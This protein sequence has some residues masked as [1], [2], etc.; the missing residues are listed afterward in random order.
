MTHLSV[1]LTGQ[2]SNTFYLMHEVP[3]SGL[4]NPAVQLKCKWFVGIPVLNS[5]HVSYGNSAFTYQ[6]LAGSDRWNLEGVFDQMHRVDLYSAAL[7]LHPLS[8]G[9]RYRSFYFNF[10][11]SEKALLLQTIPRD[12]PEVMLYGNGPFVG[13]SA[14][15]DALRPAGSYIREYALSVSKVLNPAWTVGARVKLHFGKANIYSGRS[16]L[17]LATEENSFDLLLEGD[18]TLNGSLPVTLAQDADGDITDITLNEVNYMQF[19]LNRGNPGFALDVGVIYRYDVRTTLAVSLLDVGFMRWR[20]DVHNVNGSGSFAFNGVDPGTDVISFDFLTEMGDS[21]INAYDYTVTRQPYT[22]YNPPQLYLGGSYQVKENLRV[23]VVNRNVILRNKVSSSL[24]LLAQVDLLDRFL[25]T[26]SWSY[27]NN[28][29]LNLGAGI[30][31]YGKG[32][33]FHLVSDNLPGFFFPF[34]TRTI[35]LR[36]GFN[37][38]FGCPRNKQEEMAGESYGRMPRGGDCSWSGKSKNRDKQLRKA[39]RR[40]KL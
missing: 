24:T 31:Y 1:S 12:L 32:F 28:S 30:A 19:L 33:Q 4:L 10:H 20:T 29:I 7:V 9:Y 34:N 35:N 36:A 27:L 15:F 5:M 25:A 6:D 17:R 13:E 3:Q 38:M 37:V 21:L 23:G 26:A 18:Y 14:R 22:S 39:A 2:Q 40:Q 16:D 8:I 11:I